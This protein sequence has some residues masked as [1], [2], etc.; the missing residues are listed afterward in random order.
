MTYI[1]TIKK[2]LTGGVYNLWAIREIVLLNL[3][4][5][6]DCGFDYYPNLLRGHGAGLDLW[7]ES[8]Q[9]EAKHPPCSLESTKS[10]NQAVN[11]ML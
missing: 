3:W 9:Y 7:N 5:Q 11:P 1:K 6:C 10:Q 2:A 8:I 4:V